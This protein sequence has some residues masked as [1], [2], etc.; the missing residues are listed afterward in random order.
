MNWYLSVINKYVDF[1][2]RARRK[3]YWMFFL[4]NMIISF[5]VALVG[6]LIGGKNGLFALSLPALYSLFVF[7][8]SLAVTVRRLHDTN[9]SGWWILISL[10]P[11]FGAI[12]LF[13]C[14]VLDSDPDSN[15]Y[16]PNPKLVGEPDLSFHQTAQPL[17]S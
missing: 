4:F 1:S 10:V 14:T 5:G 7:L 6:G 17:N 2:G 3:E 13:V 12:I 9:R 16:G 11:F 15:T 8:P